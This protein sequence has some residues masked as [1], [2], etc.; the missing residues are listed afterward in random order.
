[1]QLRTSL[2]DLRNVAPELLEKSRRISLALEQGSLRDVSTTVFDD[3]RRVMSMEQEAAHF[4]RLNDEW[5][6]AL[7]EARGLDSFHDLLRP[8][9]IS[10]LLS[11]AGN[12]PLVV[13]NASNTGCSALILT[14][15]R[16]SIS[17]FQG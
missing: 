8:S 12:S 17:P 7:E 14:S 11:A 13:L 5:L 16:S 3:T 2:A 1:M 15:I 4:R 9:R 6:N 10:A